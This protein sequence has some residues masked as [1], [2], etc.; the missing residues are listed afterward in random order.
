MA[1]ACVARQLSLEILQQAV[2]QGFS[3]MSRVVSLR[4]IV[5]TGGRLERKAAKNA[6]DSCLHDMTPSSYGKPVP[7][8]K[9]PVSRAGCG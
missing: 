9:V 8:G 3:I 6:V 2:S 1:L 7:V 4:I 5:K